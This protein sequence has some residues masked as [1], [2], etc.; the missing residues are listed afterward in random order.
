MVTF[1][2]NVTRIERL[3]NSLTLQI[4][5]TSALIFVC[6]FIIGLQLAVVPAFVH[7]EL[8]YNPVL[9]GLAISSQY[10]AT[11]S[12]RPFAGRMADSVGGKRAA[13]SGLL[14]CAMSGIFFS[15]LGG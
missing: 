15:S 1:Q 7:L 3:R 8:G 13:S 2:Q 4:I 6:Y 11:L 5:S 12:S 14:I 9:A 10:V